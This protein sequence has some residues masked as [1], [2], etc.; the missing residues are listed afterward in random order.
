MGSF[1]IARQLTSASLVTESWAGT[2]VTGRPVVAHQRKAPWSASPDFPARYG[3]ALRGW[4]G[5]SVP[6]VIPL[7]EAGLAPGT[8]WVIE[9]FVE[10]ESLRLAMSVAVQKRSPFSPVE[11]LGIVLQLA[12][13]LSA[14]HRLRPAVHHGDVSPSNVMVS[15]EG[16]VRLG[17]VGIAAAHPPDPS[18][19]PARAELLYVAPE[20]GDG[21]ATAAADV[22]RLGLTWL[23]LLSGR[24]VF[25]GATH[26]DVKGRL[27]RYPG[28][29]PANFPSL[30]PDLAVVLASTLAR[31]AAAR[32]DI[33]TLEQSLR[34]LFDALAPG[35]NP[36]APV[37][38]AFA[39][40]F[41]GRARVLKDLEGK[42]PLAL[43]PFPRAAPS[44]TSVGVDAGSPAIGSI[45][46][47]GAT[48]L[49]RVAPKK[50]TSD[51]LA[52]LRATELAE[53]ARAVAAEWT[54][55][56]AG[57]DDNPRDFALGSLLIEQQRVSAQHA[58][59]ALEQARSF[60]STLFYALCFAGAVDEEETLPIVADLLKQTCLTGTAMLALPLGAPQAAFLPR[61][62]AEDLRALPLRLESG[63]LTVAVKDPQR[64]D[65][66]DDLKRHGKVRAV[67]PVR[68]SERTIGE[69]LLRVYE[70]KTSPPDWATPPPKT[71]ALE[72]PATPP[73]PSS[74]GLPQ[75]GDDFSL[76]DALGLP[77][78]PPPPA[79]SSPPMLAQA[80]AAVKPANTQAPVG[81]PTIIASPRPAG[82][83]LVASS[84]K[85]RPGGREE[86]AAASHRPAAA[87][88]AVLPPSHPSTVPPVVKPS[89][90]GPSSNPS[91]EPPRLPVASA[92]LAQPAGS[93][94]NPHPPGLK[95]S[96]QA[97][98]AAARDPSA[99]PAPSALAPRRAPDGPSALDVA[100]RLFDALLSLT[101]ERGQ[102]AA[103]MLAL[104]SAVARHSG[105][106]GTA[107]DQIR[108]AAKALVIAAMLEGKR[109]VEV[110]S[111][112][113]VSACLGAHWREFEPLVQAYLDGDDTPPTDP[114][115]VV[116][117]L[118]FGLANALAAVPAGLDEA[119]P[120]LQALKDR[121]APS[122]VAALEAALGPRPASP[123]P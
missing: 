90:T 6:G 10:G 14:L 3:P 30:P 43:T 7:V 109:S 117:S 25:A 72:V 54:E 74:S 116:I 103:R 16:E 104:T 60:G 93:Q 2:T 76:L 34:T 42:E 123:T 19:G 48:T 44:T 57:H 15:T 97:V 121:F 59:A 84:P 26:S 112:P 1:R 51:D 98:A 53:A 82:T 122:V 92:P 9:E 110:P 50:V 21:Q 118:C 38:S 73:G 5:L 37:A 12:L 105:A 91:L 55:R 85:A 95:P 8:C 35:A 17:S 67:I 24:T 58:D 39:R 69:G 28:L 68:A 111:L 114:R 107:L 20:E 33:N 64:Q 40:L 61:N 62:V 52:D 101:G 56:H 102:E 115:A 87:P 63:G 49:A 4:Q 80:H 47:D 108:L 88:D 81:P 65:V 31:D 23:E 11:S 77:P 46:A 89:T 36:T 78:P 100:S 66:L 120:G 70:G 75:T 86:L 96:A 71:T 22:F 27:E 41:P 83:P 99:A 113:A 119:Q 18:L 45:N 29:T 13:G 94:L 79:S 32:P 106:I